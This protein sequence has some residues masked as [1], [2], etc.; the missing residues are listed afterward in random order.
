[1]S[2]R[3]KGW[4]TSIFP[5]LDSFVQGCTPAV[6]LT[7]GGQFFALLFLCTNSWRLYFAIKTLQ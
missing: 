3:E 7:C 2:C 4:D 6:L 5:P 1:M